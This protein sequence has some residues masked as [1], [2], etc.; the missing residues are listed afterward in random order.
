MP[1]KGRKEQALISSLSLL[2]VLFL[3][4]LSK[5]IVHT[6]FES[7]DTLPIIKHI[8]HITFVR[9]TGAAFGLCKDSTAIFIIISVAAVLVISLF[10]LKSIRK[11]EFFSKPF[12]NFGLVLILS[13]ALGNLIDRVKFGY[14]IDFIDVRIWPVFNIA[15]SAI[16]IGTFLLFIS[17]ILT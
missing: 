3:D 1:V 5:Q 17:F 2:I 4:Q 9:N 14:V 10:I 12:F 11:A 6:R 13:G 16:T 7:G 15:D 8:L